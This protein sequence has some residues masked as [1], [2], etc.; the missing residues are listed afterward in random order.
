VQVTVLAVIVVMVEGAAGDV[1][2]TTHA[3]DGSS[4]P[5]W[6]ALG[7]ARDNKFQIV[8]VQITPTHHPRRI[9]RVN[10]DGG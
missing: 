10:T 6:A 3:N 5:V 4:W 8:L 1:M 9:F 2:V 7:S